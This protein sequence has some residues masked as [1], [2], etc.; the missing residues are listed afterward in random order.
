MGHESAVSLFRPDMPHQPAQAGA[1]L[2]VDRC[3]DLH[4]MDL[5]KLADL[6]SGVWA[7]RRCCWPDAPDVVNL[8]RSQAARGVERRHGHRLQ[9][10][11][12]MVLLVAVSLAVAVEGGSGAALGV[13]GDGRC[14]E[15]ACV[16]R[17]HPTQGVTKRLTPGSY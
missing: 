7:R 1:S 4:L 3:P 6:E 2:P 11:F 12:V 14:L 9:G 17:G 13:R 8:I 5:W 15:P 16:C 10:V